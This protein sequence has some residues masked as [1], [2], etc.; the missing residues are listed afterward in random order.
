MGEIAQCYE[1]AQDI[2]KCQE[3]GCG[4]NSGCVPIGNNKR[5]GW[6]DNQGPG[7]EEFRVTC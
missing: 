6:K 1:R 5:R 3:F 2:Q 7:H 4:W